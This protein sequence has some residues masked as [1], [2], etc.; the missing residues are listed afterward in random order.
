MPK[1]PK[2]R[3]LQHLQKTVEDLVDFLAIDK[4]KIFLQDNSI[5]LGV[6]SQAGPK[7]PKQQ[8]CNILIF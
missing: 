1:V 4:H 7:H 3:N 6:S 2:I 8:V 5:T